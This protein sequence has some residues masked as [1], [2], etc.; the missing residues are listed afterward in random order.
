M[1]GCLQNK[2]Y[3]LLTI[4]F[5][6]LVFGLPFKLYAGNTG[7][8]SGTIIET[9]NG[10]SLIGANILI[11]E[12]EL[13]ASTDIN[14]KYFII[15]IPPGSYSVRASYVGYQTVTMT[16]VIISP[17]HTTELDFKLEPTNISLKNEVVV[18]AKK[19]P[20]ELDVSS[21]KQEIDFSNVKNVPLQD[22]NDALNLK[23]G[24]IFRN[25]SNDVA[26]QITPTLSIR[27]GTSIGIFV[28][29]MNVTEGIYSGSLTNFN[30]SE[31]KSAEVLTGGFNAE[32][33]NIRSGVI[34]VI[35]KEG[36]SKYHVSLDYKV[37]PAH[38]KHFGPNIYDPSSAPE[39]LLYGTNA[40]LYGPDG[41]H[42]VNNPNSYWELFS[43][44]DTVYHFT[45]EQAQ[46]VWKWQHRSRAYGNK[47]DQ[48]ID[49]SIGGPLPLIDKLNLLSNIGFFSSIRYEYNML[50]IPLSRDH[51][52][53]LNWFWK[54]TSRL[55]NALKLNIQGNY[56]QNFSSVA[57]NTPEVSVST[58]IQAVYCLQYYGT[59]YYDGQQSVADR[60]RNQIGL[61]INHVLSPSTYYDFRINYL[62]RRSFVYPKPFTGGPTFTIGGFTFDA[63]PQQGWI[64][65]ATGRDF[66]NRE[67][68]FG[69]ASQGYFFTM[70]GM[71]K[72]RDFSREELI[73]SRLDL[74]S[75]LGNYHQLK[76]GFEFNYDDLHENS[77]VVQLSPP[78]YKMNI[79][80]VIPLR[81]AY[82][83]QDKIEFKGM[84]AN[85]G[86]RMDYTNRRYD[87]YT[88]L[89]SSDFNVD[90]LYLVPTAS[91]KPFLYVSPRIGISHPISTKSKL[92]FNY[93]HF[94]S[95][96]DVNSLFTLRQRE[97]GNFDIVPNSELKPER[98]IAY[99]LGFEQQLGDEY[100]IHISGYYRDI[101]NQIKS[102]QYISH[103]GNIIQSYTNNSYADV[104]GFEAIFEK[105]L[106]DFIIGS[107]SYDYYV[108]S[109]GNIGYDV[110][111]EDIY[112]TPQLTTSTQSTP[113]ANYTF[114]TNITFSTP[115]DFGPE[116]L[117]GKILSDWQL[118]IT[119]ELRSGATFTWNPQNL[120]GLRYNV[121]WRDH[122]NT[123]LRLSRSLNLAG[124]SI[125]A[126]LEVY[127]VF[128][129]KELT[130]Y[131]RSLLLPNLKDWENYMNSLKLPSEG[132]SDQPGDYKQS[133]IQLPPPGDF[134]TQLL[135]LN[136]R[137][138]FIG[139]HVD[140]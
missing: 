73:T 27:G 139:I 118:N 52:T 85:L 17:D 69:I 131:L 40:A 105:A 140:L 98:T 60:Y 93:G 43:K 126:Y 65:T 111:Y 51:Y 84:I 53:D 76:T 87:Y 83:A 28:D 3:V 138:Y 47:P 4:V 49:A 9:G 7:K 120:P 50:T 97:A 11:L 133:Y 18:I 107:L 15:G 38:L 115:K 64:Q 128:N 132:G 67:S 41:K 75:Q 77:G 91:I 61:S 122:Q 124:T 103:A 109:A 114:L 46:A 54:L 90:S 110:I 36:G 25:T 125:E 31:L 101:T 59:K 5:L 94:Y 78:L 2:N 129:R 112:K 22:F 66:G 48:I 127:N 57:Y 71:G 19:P 6:F 23:A 81:L 72:Q 32:Y 39:W 12:T 99:E 30:M 104:R 35:T 96:P 20:I 88:N 80:H 89:Y 130:H 82:Y 13:G 55:S 21:S 56:Q 117:G 108:M 74:V 29:G 100:L 1:T 37:S 116:I 42:D 113:G 123:N 63:S 44:Y 24:V 70:G 135:F 137:F 92:F 119:H 68:D 10:E 106:G 134:P 14:G 45:P 58:P 8:I 62:L 26:E 79:F 33:G 95:E 16:N 136:P 86:V 102:V 121:R 34:N